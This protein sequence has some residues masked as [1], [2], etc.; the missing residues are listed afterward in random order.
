ML[1][2]Q[3]MIHQ[4]TMSTS[5]QGDL[6]NYVSQEIKPAVGLYVLSLAG[7]GCKGGSFGVIEA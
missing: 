1:S 2:E 5:S 4:G 7:S 3:A 6:A